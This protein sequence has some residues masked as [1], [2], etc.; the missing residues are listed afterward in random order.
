VSGHGL[1]AGHFF[2]EELPHETAMALERFLG[3][4]G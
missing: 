4:D 1:A 2:P 3:A